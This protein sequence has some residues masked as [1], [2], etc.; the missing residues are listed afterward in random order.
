LKDKSFDVE[1][2]LGRKFCNFVYTNNNLADP[3]RKHFFEKL[4]KYKKV[5]SG[6]AYLNNIGRRVKDKL[7][8]IK[9]YKFTIAFEN[10]SLPG[11]TTEKIVNPMVVN[12]MPVYWGNPEIHLDFNKESFI[13]ANDFNSL[14]EVVEEVIRL[15]KDDNAYIEKLSKPWYTGDDYSVWQSKLLSFLKNILDQDINKAERRT[16]YGRVSLYRQQQAFLYKQL[17]G[18]L[19]YNRTWSRFFNFFCRIVNR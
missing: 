14:D 16:K 11:Y 15:D 13:Y 9:N 10:S 7:V 18:K 3:A 5:D 12:S 1:E 19:H 17:G 2:M 4:S 6:G 8:F